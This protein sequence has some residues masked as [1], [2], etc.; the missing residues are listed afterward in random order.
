[1]ADE[2]FQR[3][4]RRGSEI[5]TREDAHSVHL[6]LDGLAPAR[7]YWYRF[8]A[9]GARSEVGR[10]R[11]APAQ[12]DP[13]PVRFAFCSCQ[14]YEQGYYGAYRDMA[15]QR[16]DLVVHLGDYI[17]EGSWGHEHVRHHDGGIPM[18]L[19]EFRAR[20]A[21]YK[22]DPDLQAAHAAS[23]WLV[24]WDDHEVANDYTND[25]S[26]L[27]TDPNQFLALR[28][29]A[30]RAWW[31]HMP[32]PRRMRPVGPEARIHG[33]WRFGQA[34][35]LFMLAARQHRD[36]HACV[37]GRRTSVLADCPDRF[38]AARSM[39]GR[40]QEAWLERE[41]AMPPARWTVLAQ[42]TVM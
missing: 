41:L 5:A 21:L 17:Y 3:I 30:Y 12:D 14:Q 26:P 13:Q 34:M 23:P 22:S 11:T 42:P 9:D 24:G 25:I 29:A 32:V 16:P 8:S 36:R 28:A 1:A 10:A 2:A 38:D 27:L 15:A 18:E 39:L 6:E 20:Y 7:D 31:E 19:D 4:L 37:F 35:D 40:A 33:R